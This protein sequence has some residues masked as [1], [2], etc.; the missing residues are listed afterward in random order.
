M[1]PLDMVAVIAEYERGDSPQVIGQRHGVHLATI[2]RRLEKAGVPMRTQAQAQAL[3]FGGHGDLD[4]LATEL[5][6]SIEQARQLLID[7]GFIYEGDEV[8]R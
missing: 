5:G 6:F 3:R 1:K 2:H 8:L 4:G 7:H